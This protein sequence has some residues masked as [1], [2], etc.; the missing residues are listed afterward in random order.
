MV[1]IRMNLIVSP[2]AQGMLHEVKTIPKKCGPLNV[3]HLR[4]SDIVK[5]RSKPAEQESGGVLESGTNVSF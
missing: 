1:C 2:P 4:L 3:F 5:K